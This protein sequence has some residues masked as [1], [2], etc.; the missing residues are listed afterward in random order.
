MTRAVT[1]GRQDPPHRHVG[2]VTQILRDGGR[3]LIAELL[4][5]LFGS[6]AGR[7]ASNL[8]H[9]IVDR[10][11]VAGE[12]IQHLLVI[13]RQNRFTR[14]EEESGFNYSV[15]VAKVRYAL[16]CAQSTSRK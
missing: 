6:R 16:I 4:I 5:Q 12:L 15:V 8:N 9:V 1:S 3:S 14:L 11:R 13:S 7:L 2:G 10:H